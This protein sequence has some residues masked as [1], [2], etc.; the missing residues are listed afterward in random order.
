MIESVARVAHRN[1]DNVAANMEVRPH[2]ESREVQ[3]DGHVAH[4]THLDR[5]A[6]R[7]GSKTPEESRVA[8]GDAFLAHQAHLNPVAAKLGGLK[9][10]R[11][12]ARFPG[13]LHTTANQSGSGPL[14][15]LEDVWSAVAVHVNPSRSR[16]R[17]PLAPSTARHHR[18]YRPSSPSSCSE[19]RCVAPRSSRLDWWPRLDR[20]GVASLR[21]PWQIWCLPCTTQHPSWSSSEQPCVAYPIGSCAAHCWSW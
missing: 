12:G 9:A 3:G 4:P 6:A 19:R 14:R 8:Q 2:E 13:P 21:L 18:S 17:N 11:P 7:F 1:L 16:C 20:S 5:V 15:L 10:S